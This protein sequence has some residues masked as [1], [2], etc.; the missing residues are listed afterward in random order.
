MWFDWYDYLIAALAGALIVWALNGG[1]QC[2]SR[3]QLS[4]AGL[5]GGGDS[6]SAFRVEVYQEPGWDCRVFVPNGGYARPVTVECK[7][8]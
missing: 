2:S 6:E 8:P 7:S 1:G 3:L 4:E 5:L